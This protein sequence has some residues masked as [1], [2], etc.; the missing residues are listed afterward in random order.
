VYDRE[1][2]IRGTCRENIEPDKQNRCQ[3]N[4]YKNKD[5]G[6]SRGKNTSGVKIKNEKRK[7]TAE[8]WHSHSFGKSTGFKRTP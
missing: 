2:Y 7:F 1:L 5:I 6:T 3:Y 8:Y 4:K